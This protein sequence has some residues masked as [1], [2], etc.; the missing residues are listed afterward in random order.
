[1]G[2][3]DGFWLIL[4]AVAAL[5][6]AQGPVIPLADALILN[7]VRRRA[8][9]GL[10]ALDYARVR[11]WGSASVLVMMIVGGQLLGSLPRE[12]IVW[13]L[14]G[15]A[16]ATTLIA[17]RCAQLL[18]RG[19]ARYACCRKGCGAR[20]ATPADRLVRGRRRDHPGEPCSALRFCQPAMAS[21]GP[22]R[23]L[24]RP[25]L[26]RRCSNGDAVLSAARTAAP[27]L[28]C[29]GPAHHRRRGGDLPLALHGCRTAAGHAPCCCR[30][31]MAR[32]TE[33]RSL[34]RCI[35]CPAS[36]ARSA[37]RKH[38]AGFRRR[39]H[40][41]SPRPPLRQAFCRSSSAALLIS[42]WPA[43]RLPGFCLLRWREVSSAV[44]AFLPSSSPKHG[45]NLSE[46]VT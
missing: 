5:A 37:G 7:E 40:S 41:R 21:G 29:A 32:P 12:A 28:A 15:L 25:A 46:S 27:R 33:R 31:C 30:C 14:A 11:G 19:H 3:V 9:A 42:S 43:L 8:R 4:T 18:P 17:H 38:R 24:H 6:F 2:L 16:A 45:H 39:V 26:G 20:S 44:Y 34:A 13:L 1:M 23:R 35:C 10:A 36:P 22:R